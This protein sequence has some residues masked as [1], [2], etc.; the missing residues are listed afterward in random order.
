MSAQ[1][2]LAAAPAAAAAAAGQLAYQLMATQRPPLQLPSHPS[3]VSGSH[4]SPFFAQPQAQSWQ[5]LPQSQQPPPMMQASY[6]ADAAAVASRPLTQRVVAPYSPQQQQWHQ[7]NQPQQ[8]QV[9]QL[10]SPLLSLASP[11]APLQPL[12]FSSQSLAK[13]RPLLKF[14]QPT[15]TPPAPYPAPCSSLAASFTLR[16]SASISADLLVTG[17]RSVALIF[18]TEK[19]LQQSEARSKFVQR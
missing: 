4:I 9:A 3:H 10:G 5:Q 19:E 6:T 15:V 8:S 14:G 11:A 18:V 7:T 2:T 16:Q 1:R 17:A 12:L 13:L